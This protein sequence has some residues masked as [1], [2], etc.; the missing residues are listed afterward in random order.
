MLETLDYRDADCVHHRT[1]PGK[2][3]IV[4]MYVGGFG[5]VGRY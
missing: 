5:R 4:G 3:I 2:W 1:N